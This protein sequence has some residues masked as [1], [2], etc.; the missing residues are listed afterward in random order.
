MPS[1]RSVKLEVTPVQ[2]V[3]QLLKGT[4]EEDKQ[5]KLEEQAQIAVLRQSG[6]DTMIVKK[7]AIGRSAI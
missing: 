6:D 1:E 4:I 5:E 3:T 7:R 2:K